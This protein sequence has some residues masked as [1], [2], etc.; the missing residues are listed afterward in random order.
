MNPAP[1][2]PYQGVAA[3]WLAGR[4]TAL[5]ADRPRVGK[6]AAVIR[7]SDHVLA[8]D[9]LEI[10]T[11]S[12]RVDHTRAWK[13]FQRLN[14]A[15][16]PLFEGAAELPRAGVI[17]VSFA[18]ASGPLFEKLMRRRFDMVWIDE[19]H[20]GKTP[21]IPVTKALYGPKNDRA[22]GLTGQAET[23]WTT[24]GTPAPNHQGELWTLLR[25]L[26]PEAIMSSAGRPYFYE[27]FEKKYVNVV[28]GRH[29]PQVVGAKRVDEL[30]EKIAPF[31]L[32]RTLEDVRPDLPKL[33]V[34]TLMLD[35][36]SAMARLRSLEESEKLKPLRDAIARLDA[37]DETGWEALDLDDV[38]I[39]TLRR[40]TGQA[41]VAPTIEWAREALADGTEKLVLFAQHT[42]VVNSLA[43]GLAEFKPLV[44]AG[45]VPG[46]KRQ[47]LQDAFRRPEHRI[48]IGQTQAAGEAIDLS[49]A[50][51][52]VAV[53]PSWT[54]G[55]HD[56]LGHRVVNIEK[57]RPTLYRLATL[58]GSLDERIMGVLARKAAALSQLF[59]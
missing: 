52:A 42:E 55:D 4:E 16:T 38:H 27:Q 28:Q 9:V 8:G 7:A 21:G 13:R 36:R 58:A 11:G 49:A 48:F 25:A 45:G 17:I 39:A 50:D 24:S 12:A 26:Y 10:T 18:L 30:C 29:G 44:L 31:V 35:G 47:A 56:Q 23:V 5:L 6:T 59:A 14:R 51:E 53:E 40:V 41:K 57:M 33:R 46:E 37:G 19:V 1:I 15:V 34:D 32:R 2:Y 43:E 3:E 54:P 22:D 20:R